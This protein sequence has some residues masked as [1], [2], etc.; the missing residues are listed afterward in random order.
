MSMKDSRIVTS[1]TWVGSKIVMDMELRA[2]KT[3]DLDLKDWI[4]E[5]AE[6]HRLCCSALAGKAGAGVK[7]RRTSAAVSVPTVTCNEPKDT[8][9]TAALE[10]SVDSAVFND[11]STSTSGVEM[12]DRAGQLIAS[13]LSNTNSDAQIVASKKRRARNAKKAE[14]EAPLDIPMAY[15]HS[16]LAKAH[17][18]P[19]PSAVVLN[20]TIT[21]FLDE[22]HHVQHMSLDMHQINR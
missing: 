21:L 19:R 11:A 7:K 20:G 15:I 10:E 9:I 17:F 13:A 16:L 18:L 2:T 12:P 4:P 6:L 8:S 5:A 22:G 3:H 1:P 14:Q